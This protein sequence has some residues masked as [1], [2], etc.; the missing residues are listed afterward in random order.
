MITP[1][2]G[3]GTTTTADG[4]IPSSHHWAIG[5][6]TELFNCPQTSVTGL[7]SQNDVRPVQS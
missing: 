7:Y 1:Y 3:I 4:L 2:F 5:G 6:I